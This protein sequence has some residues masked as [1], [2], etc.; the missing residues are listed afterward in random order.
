MAEIKD[1][2]GPDGTSERALERIEGLLTLASGRMLCPAIGRADQAEA[3]AAMEEKAWTSLRQY[4]FAEFAH[5]A[6]LWASLARASGERW[7]NPFS[8]VA[9]VGRKH[10]KA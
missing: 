10:R 5:Y 3:L 9:A 7:R 8:K 4:R 6:E 1:V 2:L